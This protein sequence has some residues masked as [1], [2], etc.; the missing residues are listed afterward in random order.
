MGTVF[1]NTWHLRLITPSRLSSS[2][3]ETSCR[4]K[5]PALAPHAEL[6]TGDCRLFVGDE[7]ARAT[8]VCEPRVA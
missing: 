8:A 4:S 3:A 2:L 7:V 5:V 6:L 1:L